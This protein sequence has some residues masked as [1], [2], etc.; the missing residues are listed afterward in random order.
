MTQ[1][2]ITLKE[3]AEALANDE[4][5]FYYQPKVLM[6]TGEICGA[7]A[8]IRWKQPDGSLVSPAAFIPLA[9]STGFINEITLAMFQ[10]LVIDMNIIND[11][12]NSLTVSFNA[13]AKDFHNDKL[14]E[15]I[16]YAVEHKIVP[17]E[18]LEVELT[19]TSILNNLEG[20]K[21]K[22]N[23]L[24]T[25]GIALAMDDYGTGFSN[26]DTLAKWPFSTIKLDQGMISKLEASDR[27]FT[28]V[29][30]SIQMAHQLELDIVAEGIE[31]EL[32]YHILQNMG[33]TQAQ[34]YWISRPIA[35]ADFLE[36]CRGNRHWPVEPIGLIHI[37]QHDHISWRKAIIDGV[38]YLGLRKNNLSIRGAPELDPTK[39]RLGK[40][41]Y[42]PGK[43]FAGIGGY[44]NF[45]VSHNR[46]HQ[47]GEELLEA[48][49]SGSTKSELV[50]LMRQLTEQSVLVLG[51]L[52]EIENEIM[53]KSE[54]LGKLTI[55]FG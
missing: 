51:M 4:F 3:I 24:Q 25:M 42:G 48:A 36:L 9:E 7:E 49:K 13:S 29:Q 26:I 35:L 20:V 22:L 17:A 19:E 10:K 40:W 23:K 12:K 53:S 52:Q 11:T 54:K 44:D 41:Y 32:V 5:V 27:E 45:E 46:L 1:T 21:S 31:S 37:A 6:L 34:G 18:L 55:P 8:L 30:S 16:R 33:C 50:L 14:V 38:Y 39:C 15:A 47:I 2:K 28:I 43:L